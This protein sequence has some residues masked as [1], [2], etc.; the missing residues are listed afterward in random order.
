MAHILSKESSPARGGPRETAISAILTRG[1]ELLVVKRCFRPGDP[2][3]SHWALPGGFWKD[4]DENI[5]QTVIREVGEEVGI[6]LRGLKLIGWLKPKASRRAP[7]IVVYPALFLTDEKP[8]VRLSKELVDFR[9]VPL[10][11][12]EEGRGRVEMEGEMLDTDIFRWRDVVI[13][14]LTYRVVSELRLISRDE[15]GLQ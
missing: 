5:L 14:G 2:W 8:P 7:D 4:C 10:F 15:L 9:W 13:W 6:D 3:S 1:G 12:L 11:G